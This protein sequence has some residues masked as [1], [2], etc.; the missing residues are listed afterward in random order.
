[1]LPGGMSSGGSQVSAQALMPRWTRCERQGVEWHGVRKPTVIVE[2]A[3]GR[4]D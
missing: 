1:M 3:G 4:N 2:G